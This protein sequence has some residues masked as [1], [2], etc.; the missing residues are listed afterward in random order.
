MAINNELLAQALTQTNHDLER[1]KAPAPGGCEPADVFAQALREDSNH[2]IDWLWTAAHLTDADQRR[3]CLERA[4]AINP[5]NERA[6]RD[7]ARLTIAPH[8]RE[9]MMN[10]PARSAITDPGHPAQVVEIGNTIT[11][12]RDDDNDIVL[13]EPTI[14]RWHALLLPNLERVAVMDLNSM[15]GTFVNGV[16]APP[17]EAIWLADGD[18]IRLGPAV[19]LRYYARYGGQRPVVEL[20]AAGNTRGIS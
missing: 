16:L 4:L 18:E 10:R 12:G 13:V 2:E 14:S 15:N 5:R 11:I 7:L 17:D 3:Y 1:A 8:H 19:P 6:R 9:A 20:V